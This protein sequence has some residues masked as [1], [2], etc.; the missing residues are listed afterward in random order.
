MYPLIETYSEVVLDELLTGM[1]KVLDKNPDKAFSIH[2]L[3]GRAVD[4]LIVF[5]PDTKDLAIICELM[6]DDFNSKYLFV[7]GTYAEIKLS[8]KKMLASLTWAAEKT[9]ATYIESASHRSGWGKFTG[10]FDIETLP[11]TT[12][13]IHL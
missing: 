4:D 13:R 12:Y 7:W 2:K 10:E 11:M 8:K 6:V 3:I 5:S 1:K 9:G